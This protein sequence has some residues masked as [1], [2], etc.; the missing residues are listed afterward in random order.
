MFTITQWGIV[1]AGLWLLLWLSL[2]EEKPVGRPI[3][4]ATLYT[5]SLA[6]LAYLLSFG[7]TLWSEGTG[8]I[9]AVSVVLLLLAVALVVLFFL[10]QQVLP[11]GRRGQWVVQ[12]ACGV[13]AVVVAG[14]YGVEWLDRSQIPEVI[15]SQTTQTPAP[16]PPAGELPLD[17]WF[18]PVGTGGADVTAVM[19]SP[20]YATDHAFAALDRGGS[21]FVWEDKQQQW[22]CVSDGFG[23]ERPTEA[24]FSPTFAT[25]RTLYL[26]TNRGAFATRD[27]GA[28][29]QKVFGDGDNQH[30]QAVAVGAR[31]EGHD[32]FLASRSGLF[33]S[34]DAGKTWERVGS[35]LGASVPTTLAV[36]PAY[37]RDQTL[38]AGTSR[39]VFR[40]SDGGSSWQPGCV[41][42][43]NWPLESLRCYGDA[44]KGAELFMAVVWDKDT[45][46][47]YWSV[48][49]ENQWRRFGK[50]LGT[51]LPLRQEESVDA[52]YPFLTATEGKSDGW[53]LLYGPEPGAVRR[54]AVGQFS[55]QKLRLQGADEWFEACAALPD[56]RVVLGGTRGVAV[57]DPQKQGWSYRTRGLRGLTVNNLAASEKTPRKLF[58]AT[59][60]GLYEARDG[61]NWM[62]HDLGD[63][64]G[65]PWKNNPTWAVCVVPAGGAERVLVGTDAGLYTSADGGQT[66]QPAGKGG[67]AGAVQA[68]VRSPR[69]AQDHTVYTGG[70]SGVYRS[71]D[72][73][74]GWEKTDPGLAERVRVLVAGPMGEQGH[75]LFAGTGR[76]VFK[77][78]DQGKSWTKT[79]PGTGDKPCRALAVSPAYAS[80]STVWAALPTGVYRSADAGQSWTEVLLDAGLRNRVWSIRLTQAAGGPLHVWLGS[81]GL[82][83]HE[84]RDN[85]QTW[86][87][88]PGSPHRLRVTSFFAPEAS[89]GV[90]YAGVLGGSVW[91]YR[92]A[93]AGRPA[94]VPGRTGR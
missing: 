37:E 11:A 25:D 50:G 90:V 70:P 35:E 29:W 91:Q 2:R 83:I 49:G 5:L 58:A 27:S 38:W 73:G 68:L 9:D 17:R 19:V 32:V 12:G 56:G 51:A 45:R 3:W 74:S 88:M 66:W 55:W 75:V 39:G 53:S 57:L 46:R 20:G 78:I 14:L 92:A 4:E 10:D 71:T 21:L 41:Y 52:V 82:G 43:R 44:Q 34:K 59:E 84:S 81:A 87:P 7:W 62:R 64:K 48:G 30:L 8:D 23:F 63:S 89:G 42:L 28:T 26:A 69:F 93:T 79:N 61:A 31:H 94:P 47:T 36:S 76:G 24:A 40:S 16:L 18:C 54:S 85:G 86:K 67:P 65:S 15:C 60:Q 33:R 80:D 77:S 1:L 72:G 22:R 6:G 13:L